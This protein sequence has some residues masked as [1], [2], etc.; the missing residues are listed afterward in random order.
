MEHEE[1]SVLEGMRVI[2]CAGGINGPGAGC[3]LGMLGAE[4]I[5]IEQPGVGA[6]ERGIDAV[7]GTG[8]QLPDGSAIPVHLFNHSKK[9]VTID[10]NKQE[11][12][13]ILYR[14]VQRSDVFITNYRP[15]VIERLKIDYETLSGYNARL[16]YGTT[17]ALGGKG[18]ERER[19]SFDYIGQAR[20]GM[21]MAMGERNDSPTVMVG[22]PTDQLGAIML[23]F[24]VL[25]AMIA[26]ERTGHGQRVDTSMMGA[27]LFMQALHLGICLFRGK[28]LKR[29]SRADAK[30]PLSNYYKCKDGKWI[31]L[32]EIQVQRFWSRF[33]DALGMGELTDDPRF[34]TPER[35][36]EHAGELVKILDEV[37][38]TRTRDEWMK[39]LDEKVGL[40]CSPIHTMSEVT[41][42][43]QVLENGYIVEFDHPTLGTIRLPGFPVTLTRTPAKIRSRAPEVGEHTEEVLVDLLGYSWEEIEEFK[44]REVI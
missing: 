4:V 43:P 19:R 39:I 23:A 34:M 36:R 10:L 26:R 44:N 35:M 7:A 27:A 38:A 25:A 42:D 22:A 32:T 24:G 8:L 40:A 1:E 14:L 12:R 18:P 9:S 17:S 30:A 41:E 13:E 15:S 28:E 5:K 29:H 31:L 37:F 3:I 21:M 16:I 2:E 33:C 11:G 6:W 20:S